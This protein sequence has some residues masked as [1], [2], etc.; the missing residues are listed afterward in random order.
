MEIFSAVG[1]ALNTAFNMFWD[2]LWPLVLGFGLSAVVQ[3][4]VSH[5]AMARLL[6]DDSPRSLSLASLFG[7]ASSSCSYAA[8]ALA[9]SIFRKGASFTAA[10]V[11]EIASTNLVIELGVILIVLL[12]W[13]FAASEFL[14]GILMVIFI[15]VVFRVTLTPRLMEIARRHADEGRLGRMEGH[16]AMD[17]SVQGGSFLSRLFSGRGFTATSHIFVMDWASVWVDVAAGF[18]IAGAVA[19]WVPDAFWR[20]FF[21]TGHST[22][23]RIEGPLVGPLVSMLSFV[24][25]IGNV[26]LAAVL[27]RG[28]ISFGGVVSFIFADLIILPILDIYRRYYGGKVAL[29][30]LGTFYITMAAAGYVV[31]LLF[32]WLGLIPSNR[33]VG[34]ITQGP[35]WNYTSVLNIVF[36]AIAAALVL[37]FFRTGGPEMLS[38]ME[39]TEEEM[40][41]HGD[42]AMSE[43]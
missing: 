8:T 22:L 18:L 10:M 38:M 11:F 5:Q 17:M 39:M 42:V 20:D 9:R 43:P 26:P 31:E 35:I 2:V 23:A 7:I 25:S 13:Q 16:G 41:H 33:N 12:G 14:G 34:V 1:Q 15:A 21:L 28:G 24:C 32:E 29:Y 40:G 19:A 30:I 3:V 37:R 6:G 36:L 4:F 27:W